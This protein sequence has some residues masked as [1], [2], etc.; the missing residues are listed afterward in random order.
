LRSSYLDIQ[1]I[2]LLEQAIPNKEELRWLADE[3]MLSSFQNHTLFDVAVRPQLFHLALAK[4]FDH[5]VA[6]KSPS[7]AEWCR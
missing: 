7:R 3:V 5:D 2:D 6:F 4:E 1:A